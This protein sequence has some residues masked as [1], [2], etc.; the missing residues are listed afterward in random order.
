MLRVDYEELEPSDDFL[1]MDY[2]GQPFNG[3]A[4]ENDEDGNLVAETSFVEGQK[5]GLSRE[6]SAWGTIVREQWFAH[7]SLHGPSRG[8]YDNGSRKCDGFY[9]FGICV[10]ERE[11]GVNGS[12]TKR[13]FI[14]EQGA[15][16]AT[17]ITLRN[18]RNRM[19]LGR[20][21][22]ELFRSD[23]AFAIFL[24]KNSNRR[25]INRHQCLHNPKQS[26]KTPW[27]VSKQCK[28]LRG[29]WRRA[30]YQGSGH[31]EAEARLGV[32][33]LH[34][35]TRQ[36][37][38]RRSGKLKVDVPSPLAR[39][40]LLPAL[41]DFHAR[42]PDLQIDLG[43]SDRMIALIGETSIAWCA[44]ACSRTSSSRRATWRLAAGAVCC[45]SLPGPCRRART[46]ARVGRPAPLHRGVFIEARRQNLSGFENQAMGV[47]SGYFR[48]GFSGAGYDQA[49]ADDGAVG[50][51]AI[52]SVGLGGFAAMIKNAGKKFA[53]KAD[54]LV[55]PQLESPE[56]LYGGR[57]GERLPGKAGTPIS[58]RPTISEVE[59]LTVKHNVEFAVTLKMGPGKMVVVVNTIY[60]L[61]YKEIA[62]Y[63][64]D[65]DMEVMK[66]LKDIGSPQRSSLI[67][68]VDSGVIVKLG[69]GRDLNSGTGLLYSESTKNIWTP[70]TRL[71]MILENAMKDIRNF[72]RGGGE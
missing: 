71:I 56:L 31:A 27:T 66:Y 63:A 62:R 70:K 61:V 51:G 20:E 40:I 50:G 22:L 42:N 57:V 6:W 21:N 14:D 43:V 4:F 23:C 7:N 24:M 29:R 9:E 33:L 19:P 41:P 53:S 26:E 48:E 47:V 65:A 16:F 32:Q 11:W 44:A 46:T 25:V 3:V 67:I 5:N 2:A 69:I 1:L 58:G 37:S 36:A 34:R 45:T 49:G 17:L 15:Q 55:G 8:W 12:E 39:M 38:A 35:T 10:K 72:L 28:P 68:P 52:I 60:I 13:Y 64:S 30:V 54:N 59:N 18:I